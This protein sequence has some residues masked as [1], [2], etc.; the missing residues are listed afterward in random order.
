M[1]NFKFNF[2]LKNCALLSSLVVSLATV[3]A[4]CSTGSG[5]TTGSGGSPGAGTGGSVGTGGSAGTKTDGGGTGGA[6]TGTG[7]AVTAD[8][9]GTGGASGPSVCDGVATRV[10][11]LNEGKVDNFEAAVLSPGWST[12]NDVMPTMNAFKMMQESGGA[13][14]TGHFGHYAGMGAKTPV[15]GGFGV[16][17]IYNAAIDKSLGF[18]CIDISAFTGVTFWA[19]AATAGSKV[20][21]NFVVPETN[22]KMD[23]G[24]C[25]SGCYVHPA[26]TIALTTTWAQYSV[27]FAEAAG[28]T[29]KVKNRI[30][31]LGFLSPDTTWDFSLD[32][33]QFYSGTAP[34]GPVTTPDGGI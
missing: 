14:G 28:G 34:T 2:H 32:E 4:G 18:Y 33:I 25:L 27:T 9:G 13:L 5:S 12:F 11:T 15:M 22:A 26:K 8:G 31:L 3:V 21:V 1:R 6:S 30:Q 16:G 10:L 29:A 19:K 24:D 17:A 20:A 23:D 7:G